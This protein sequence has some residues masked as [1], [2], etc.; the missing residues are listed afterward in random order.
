MSKYTAAFK[1]A[2]VEE[3]L[4]AEDCVAAIAKHHGLRPSMV[5]RWVAFYR[6]HGVEGL[7]RKWVTYDA[8]FRHSVLVHMW[9][10]SFSYETAAAH[11]NI[12]HAGHV[13]DWE[14]KY[15]SGGIDALHSRPLGR[16]RKMSDPPPAPPLAPGQ[17]DS[18]S[19]EEL[20][21]ELEYLRMENA[22]L[23][24]LSALVQAQK[25]SAQRRKRK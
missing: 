15:Q 22:Y 25:Q 16:P 21:K 7:K 18:R 11:F 2:V 10:N 24:K 17:D 5:R 9:T 4:K 14:R 13:A 3:C 8:D 6:L 20:L 23:K 12:R 1:Q 19:R